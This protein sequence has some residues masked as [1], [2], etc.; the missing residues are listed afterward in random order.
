MLFEKTEPI[1]YP[2]LTGTHVTQGGGPTSPQEKRWLT[3]VGCAQTAIA[4]IACNLLLSVVAIAPIQAQILPLSTQAQL[5][6]AGE[7]EDSSLEQS[8]P[9]EELEVFATA[10]AQ[11]V[12]LREEAK[13]DLADAIS[14][15][16]L[17]PEQFL[18]IRDGNTEGVEREELVRF[19]RA[20]GA[21]DR[22]RD[23]LEQDMQQ[24]VE[25]EGMTVARFQEIFAA[26]EDTPELQAR[27]QQ[28][29]EERL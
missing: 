4:A 6:V 8:L 18:D 10:F 13:S 7:G 26:V 20:E 14:S 15:E 9:Q 5:D 22:V 24:V 3:I 23:S 12:E 16:N 25:E 1:E 28:V 17:T 29:W 2:L 11:M 21:V 19:E 27:L